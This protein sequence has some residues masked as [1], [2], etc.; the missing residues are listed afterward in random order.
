MGKTASC[1]S[2][3]ATL[4]AN[5]SLAHTESNSTTQMGH[6]YWL[7]EWSYYVNGQVHSFTITNKR[8]QLVYEEWAGS[9]KMTGKAT[10][11]SETCCIKCKKMNFEIELNRE[12][13]TARYRQKGSKKWTKKIQLMKLEE[14]SL[15]D[16]MD[17]SS[18]FS[19]QRSTLRNTLKNKTSMP[20]DISA[21]KSQQKSERS[22]RWF[23]QD[24]RRKFFADVI[25]EA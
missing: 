5:T 22:L 18:T 24:A 9:V 14:A 17:G 21:G 4:Q 2:T 1:M 13:Q 7:G 8:G 3:P 15:T 19:R 6:S 12:S 20:C 10:A 23:D 11:T 16:E 25:N